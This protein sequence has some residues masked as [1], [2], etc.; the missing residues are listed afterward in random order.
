MVR[1]ISTM[2]KT[3][4]TREFTGVL[5]ENAE[6][7]T[8][9]LAKSQEGVL[10]N[11][12]IRTQDGKAYNYACNKGLDMEHFKAKTESVCQKIKDGA[13]LFK[14]IMEYGLNLK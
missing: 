13:K 14:E 7:V 2:S 3:P 6:R 12:S 10:N 4:I 8:F 1:N 11:L 5:K 9:N